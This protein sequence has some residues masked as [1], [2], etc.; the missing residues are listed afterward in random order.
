MVTT[1]V[2]WKAI[3]V[4]LFFLC[5]YLFLLYIVIFI[6]VYITYT[7]TTD[8]DDTD[9]RQELAEKGYT[10][11]EYAFVV[12]CD[13]ATSGESGV[14]EVRMDESRE[15][16]DDGIKLLR[17]SYIVKKNFLSTEKLHKELS[18]FCYDYYD[19]QSEFDEI[20][21]DFY[22]E[23]PEMPWFWNNDGYFYDLETNWDNLVAVYGI[24]KEGLAFRVRK[25]F[26]SKEI[27]G[28]S[29]P[30]YQTEEERE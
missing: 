15:Y 1:K 17:K 16:E 26:F 9:S 8:E 23:C 2:K 5:L 18:S 22:R 29:P 12:E 25:T 28:C 24:G 27:F 21:F 13:G 11:P 6:A 10:L 7:Y 20:D 30:L 14:L 4:S 19:N 3:F